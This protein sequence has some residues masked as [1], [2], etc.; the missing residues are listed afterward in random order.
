MEPRLLLYEGAWLSVCL[1]LETFCTTIIVGLTECL[2]SGTEV[3]IV[4]F[5]E[6]KNVLDT[7]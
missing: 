6:V 1:L 4:R 2:L 5:S 3:T 7:C